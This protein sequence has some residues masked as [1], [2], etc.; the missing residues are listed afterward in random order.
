MASRICP[1]RFFGILIINTVAAIIFVTRIFI[2]QPA[3]TLLTRSLH[4]RGWTPLVDQGVRVLMLRAPANN[5]PVSS[6]GAGPV[7]CYLA[8]GLSA[9]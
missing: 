1:Q 8:V 4:E 6:E 9:Q 7:G 5:Q 3:L 2:Y